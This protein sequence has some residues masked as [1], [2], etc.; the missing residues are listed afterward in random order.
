MW[1]A[2]PGPEGE[3]VYP[4][5]DD[6][7]EARWSVGKDTVEKWLVEDERVGDSGER[8]IFWKKR[9][10]HFVRTRPELKNKDED[11]GKP[12]WRLEAEGTHWVPYTR[13]WAPD[14]PTRPWPTIWFAS[15]DSV[16]QE[17]SNEAMADEEFEGL[18]PDG[19]IAGVL[20]EIAGLKMLDDVKTTRQAKAHLRK[21]FPGMKLFETPKP[22]EL[23]T[24]IIE[25]ATNEGDIVLDCFAGSGSTLTTAHKLE[26]RW[27][28]IE[29]ALDTLETFTVPR[30][31]KVVAGED[32]WGITKRV[33]W[34]G[35]GGFRVLDVAQSMFEADGGL[36]FLA[37]R[38]TNGALAEATA[39][40][41][42][43]AY[44]ADPPFAGRKGKIRLAVV[45][46]VVNESV[47]RLL[48][49]ALGNGDRVVVCG[50]GID[51][52]ARPILR[53]L[54]PGSTLR[55]IP[56]ALLSEYRSSRQLR[57]DLTAARQSAAGDGADSPAGEVKV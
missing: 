31:Q 6:G 9:P 42:G 46:G 30:L 53:E 3:H 20:A 32:E 37:E 41:L 7:R 54:R 57:L 40:Q 38:M 17:R 55:K 33:G 45:D 23:M 27:V 44:E 19:A 12:R 14:A 18:D 43:Y 28:G 16:A 11:D 34:E 25:I 51:T 56:A 24:R 49:S 26:R 36:V 1:F 4:I 21:L 50:T 13:E 29:R 47:V 8:N 15:P 39:A 35:G 52:D 10:G 5:H 48:V 22:E 2:I